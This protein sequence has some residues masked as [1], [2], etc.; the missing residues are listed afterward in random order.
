MPSII[1]DSSFR[2][3]IYKSPQEP[4]FLELEDGAKRV[5]TYPLA[6]SIDRY[7]KDT[8]RIGGL[9]LREIGEYET[10]PA[11]GTII[12]LDTGI[13]KRG[14]L[15]CL[16]FSCD[17]K[18]AAFKIMIDNSIIVPYS[19]NGDGNAGVTIQSLYNC[20]GE[21]EYLKLV[22]YDT[23]NDNYTIVLKQPIDFSMRLR[24]VATAAPMAS[25]EIGISGYYVMID[26]RIELRER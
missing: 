12:V 25:T 16:A 13:R 4:Q 11:A 9:L 22:K 8:P 10:V 21:N 7:V 26:D 6:F 5:I 24:I 19:Q 20:G 14:R 3:T 23:T 18:L 2:D 17:N 15:H 1:R